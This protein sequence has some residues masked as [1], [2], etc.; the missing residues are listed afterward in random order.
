MACRPGM[1]AVTTMGSNLPEA[2]EAYQ[3]ITR[4]FDK[5][6]GQRSDSSAIALRRYPNSC[7][8]LSADKLVWRYVWRDIQSIAA[9][10][11]PATHAIELGNKFR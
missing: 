5:H 7:H 3:V 4:F 8:R 1:P 10:G 6:L 9:L 2:R 11:Q